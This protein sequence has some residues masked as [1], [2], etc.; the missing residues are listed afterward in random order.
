MATFLAW[1]GVA[2]GAVLVC[3]RF[4]SAA[5]D[6]T[7]VKANFGEE[8]RS[9]DD[10]GAVVAILPNDSGIELYIR[11]WGIDSL[12]SPRG[13]VV[14][15]HGAMWHS[16]YFMQFAK[17]LVQNGFIV[18]APDLQAHGL[19]GSARGV[20]GNFTSFQEL[21]DDVDAILAFARSN[22]KHKSIFIYGESMGAAIAL[23]WELQHN[24]KKKVDGIM[25]SGAV[26]K[27]REKGL[28]NNLTDILAEILALLAP[29]KRVRNPFWETV[30][31]DSF[32]NSMISQIVHKDPL[33]MCHTPT[34]R[35]VLEGHHVLRELGRNL[36]S[37]VTP[38]LV[39][40]GVED[41]R[42]P[43]VHSTLLVEEAISNDKILK[44]YDGMK[45]HLLHD[46]PSN[47]KVVVDDI[48]KWLKSRTAGHQP[49]KRQKPKSGEG[50][51]NL[52]DVPFP[53]SSSPAEDSG[54]P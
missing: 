1:A 13:V 49:R 7:A 26:V 6:R 23:L 36:R 27:D 3:R 20:R 4:C 33:V 10:T 19:S 38:L 9:P 12:E 5:V 21:A 48:M 42:V 22:H 25:L 8:V 43:C 15:V 29:D 17:Q 50:E 34:L 35:Y 54:N 41:T 16:W 46:E 14:I 47:V 40:H 53:T 39:M 45:H 18:Y 32:G 52:P 51:F 44:L 24:G 28:L 37:I 31:D 2:T 30:F 11:C